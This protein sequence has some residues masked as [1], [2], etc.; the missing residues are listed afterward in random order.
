MNDAQRVVK[1]LALSISTSNLILQGVFA[2]LAGSLPT[3]LPV[4]LC[5]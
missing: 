4:K 1:H 2:H 5:C 3:L